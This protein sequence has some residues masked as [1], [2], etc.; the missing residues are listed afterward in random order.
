[1]QR[2]WIVVEQR[3]WEKINA[4]IFGK[5]AKVILHYNKYYFGLM[6]F[7]NNNSAEI[8]IDIRDV[9]KRFFLSTIWC[10]ALL[11]K[12]NKDARLSVSNI[13]TFQSFLTSDNFPLSS[14]PFAQTLSKNIYWNC[15]NF[16]KNVRSW[17]L[18][19]LRYRH[20]FSFSAYFPFYEY[21][22]LDRVS[23]SFIFLLHSEST[24]FSWLNET[25]CLRTTTDNDDI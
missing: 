9:S 8:Q 17:K 12:S 14:L 6:F 24:Q 2:K 1:M 5:N 20:S 18:T 13:N 16:T 19:M 10:R 11:S 21:S 15:K 23:L 7:F 4:K 22:K 3:D 25:S